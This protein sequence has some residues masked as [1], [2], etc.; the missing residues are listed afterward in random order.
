MVAVPVFCF[1]SVSKPTT[2]APANVSAPAL[3]STILS[4]AACPPAS[5]TV[6]SAAPSWSVST[7]SPPPREIC[8]CPSTV[9]AIVNVSV[10]EVQVYVPSTVNVAPAATVVVVTPLTLRREAISNVPPWT[11]DFGQ[12]GRRRAVD[13]S[14]PV[15][16]FVRPSNHERADIGREDDVVDTRVEPGAAVDRAARTVVPS[17][18]MK[19]SS[20][21]PRKRWP[22]LCRACRRRQ[23]VGPVCEDHASASKVPPALT[24]TA[25]T[26]AL[27]ATPACV[28]PAACTVPSTFSVVPTAARADRGRLERAVDVERA[29]GD[30]HA[31]VNCERPS[32]S[33]CRYS[34]SRA[35]RKPTVSRRRTSCAGAIEARRYRW[36]SARRRRSRHSARR[37]PAAYHVVAGA[38]IDAAAA[39]DRA[40][41]GE[42]I[43]TWALLV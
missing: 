18:T 27:P 28:A 36:S 43:V 38:E 25:L 15:P 22:V 34:P 40:C 32:S 16:V 5:I 6:F 20:P 2:F 19:E 4:P 13:V 41:Y 42:S 8:R 3:S 17:W 29:A 30:R 26:P 31:G 10:P 37:R 39:I 7:S 11:C 9:P 12:R 14:V 23:D 21:A 24:T 33:P 1:T 35:V